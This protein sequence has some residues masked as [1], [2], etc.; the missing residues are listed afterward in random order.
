MSQ[1][2]IQKG[3]PIP[4]A[5]GRGARESKYPFADMEIGDSF[6]V[7]DAKQLQSARNAAYQ[8]KRKNPDFNYGAMSNPTGTGQ[9]GGRLWRIE[10]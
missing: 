10:L 1:F 9:P 8:Y 4:T 5:V 6:A 2:P 7:H 3:V